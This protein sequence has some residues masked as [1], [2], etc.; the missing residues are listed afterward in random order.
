MLRLLLGRTISTDA[1]VA[2]ATVHLALDRAGEVREGVKAK[3]KA[4]RF[5][6]S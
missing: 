3:G 2:F 4:G 1:I 6:L 5:K